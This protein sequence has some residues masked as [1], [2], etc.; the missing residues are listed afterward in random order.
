MEKLK[1]IKIPI[2]SIDKQEEIVNY[3]DLVNSNIE[4][5]KK[6]IKVNKQLSEEFMKSALC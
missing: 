1:S 4:I 3:L 6:E 5:L 2:P